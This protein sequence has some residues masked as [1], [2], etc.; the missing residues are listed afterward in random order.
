MKT[1]IFAGGDIH[2]LPRNLITQNDY[3]IAA[4]GGYAFAKKLNITP[5]I[6]IGDFDSQNEDEI[7]GKTLRLPTNKNDTDTLA[8]VKHALAQSATEIIIAGA[9]GGRFDHTF[10]NLQTLLYIKNAG[11]K[12]QIIGENV[13]ITL[14]CNEKVAISKDFYYLSVFAFDGQAEGVT[15]KNVKYPLDNA[16]LTTN[17]PIG[18]SNEITGDSA[19][20]SVKCG[21]LLIIEQN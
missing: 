18:V 12:A 11:A 8:A 10:A 5:H 2:P 3:I 20:I 4:D 19:K 13:Q 6:T 16:V 17:F 7:N 14:L 15:I 9:L 21:N 1:I